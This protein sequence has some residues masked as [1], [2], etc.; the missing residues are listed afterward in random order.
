MTETLDPKHVSFDWLRQNM[1]VFR[2]AGAGCFFLTRFA[3]VRACLGDHHLKNS[4]LAEPGTFLDKAGRPVNPYR[5]GERDMTMGYLDNPDHE[6]IRRQIQIAF[7]KRFAVCRPIIDRIIAD[8]L[9]SLSTQDT[10]DV[11]T[12]YS[13]PVPLRANSLMVGVNAADL[14]QFRIWTEDGFKMFQTDRTQAET[15]AM[16]DALE[17]FASYFER[18]IVERRADPREDLVSDLVAAQA[19]GA[20]LTD[21]EIRSNCVSLI[22]AAIMT[23]TDLI[24][25]TI[26]LLLQHP[27]QLAMLKAQPELIR[28]AIEEVLRI[29]P[30]VESEWRIISR[31]MEI[32]GCPVRQGQVVSVSLLAANRDP[33]VFPEP[34]QFNILRDPRPH[35]SFGGGEHICMGAPLG[36]LEAQLAVNAFFAR[37]PNARL[38]EPDAPAK[39]RPTPYFPGLAEL[40][41]ARE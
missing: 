17:G 28:P 12:G 33:Q 23:T 30:P 15:D 40:L 29:A 2:D 16:G 4:D 11:V 6:R 38:C 19:A 1:P 10:F 26:R 3:D 22:A 24:G 32:N 37:F 13:I 5:P 21:H 31:D 39:R 20:P 27:E 7:A 14:A 18:L 36:R 35:M 25:S 9:D 34:H 41:V 8:A